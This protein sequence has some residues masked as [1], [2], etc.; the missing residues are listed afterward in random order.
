MPLKSS[1]NICNNPWKSCPKNTLIQCRAIWAISLIILRQVRG[2]LKQSIH[3]PRKKVHRMHGY[4]IPSEQSCEIPWE[5]VRTKQT[6]CWRLKKPSEEHAMPWLT[7]I[8][9]Q[10]PIT[11]TKP[12][13]ANLL[14]RNTSWNHFNLFE[15][16]T[17]SRHLLSKNLQK[18]IL[19]YTCTSDIFWRLN[20]ELYMTIPT[21]IQ[22]ISGRL[23]L[24]KSNGF[25]RNTLS[26]LSGWNLWFSER[27]LAKLVGLPSCD[28]VL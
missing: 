2:Q 14:E 10:I 19:W 25:S 20:F 23:L 1:Q 13:C 11:S 28:M 15:S 7:M 22:E 8:E 26:W 17:I 27:T 12:P 24:G 4:R 9:P 18:I 21:S 16:C 3:W 6:K 5:H